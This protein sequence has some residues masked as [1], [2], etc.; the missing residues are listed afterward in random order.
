MV[1]KIHTVLQVL[2]DE[3]IDIACVQET[4]LSSESSVTTSII[5]QA[6]YNISHVFRNEKRG[7]GVAILWKEKFKSFKQNCKVQPKTYLSLQH[8]CAVFNFNPKLIIISIYRLQEIPFTVFLKEL[9]SLINDHFNLTHSLI[10]IG[11]FNAHFE[12]HELHDT[13]LLSDLTSSFGLSQLIS[14]PTHKAGHTLDLVFLNNFELQFTTTPPVSFS[15]GDHFPVYLTLYNLYSPIM[16]STNETVKYRDIRGINLVEFSADLCSQLDVVSSNEDFKSQ[17]Q[18]FSNITSET[19]ERHAPIKTKTFARKNNIPWQDS[20]YRKERA[21]RRKL[22]RKWRK[23]GKKPGPERTAYIEQRSKC[24][25][26]A[27]SKRSHFY[28]QLIQKNEGDQSSLFKVVSQVLDKQKSSTTLPQF[29]NQPTNLANRFNSYYFDKVK[30]IRAEI[31]TIDSSDKF[32]CGQATFNGTPL[33][34]FDPVSVDELSEILKGRTIKT[35]HNDVLPR[36][37]MKGVFKDLLPYICDLINLSLKTGCMDGVTEATIVPL[38]KKLGLDP[39]VLK[40]YRPVSDIVLISKLIETVVLKRLN[41][42]ADNH[43]LQCH[44]QHAYKKYHSTETLLLKVV[45]D[46]LVGYDSNNATILFLLD[47]S[48]AFDTVDSEKLLLILENEYGIKG[49]ALKWFRSFLIGRT[50]RVRIHESLSDCLDVLFGVPQGSVLGPVLF[51]IYTRSLY[52]IISAAG[53]S[54]SGYADDSN[55]R[56]SF[57]LCFQHN[58]ITQQLPKLM[59]QITQWM[60][61]FFLKINPDKTEIILFLPNARKNHPTINGTFFSNG[62]CIRFSEVVTNLGIKL[63]RFLSFE[64]HVNSTVAHCYKLLKDVSSIRSL[65]TI[66]ETEM[67]VHSVIT[68]RLDYCNSLFYNLN[69]SIIDKFQKVQNAAARVVLKLKKHDSV[70]AELVNLHW[71]RINERIIFKLLVTIFKCLNGLA[72]VELRSLINLNDTDNCTLRYIFMDSVYGRR[73]FQYAA[74]RLWN[75]LPIAVRKISTLDNF[76]SKIKYHLFNHSSEFMR[77]VNRYL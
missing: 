18:Q 42:H 63:D 65:I 70:R 47:L 25:I 20:E 14:G 67:L 48:A 55:A 66:H 17:Y 57:S 24:G 62:T 75:A 56:Q 73:S 40:N 41:K 58:I 7:A 36:A 49:M 22:E 72:P 68:S 8:Q 10:L 11:D 74:P 54:T 9:D 71:L 50:Q 35:A 32:D 60:N 59:D 43:N 6:G 16:Q 19:L 12:R 26:L 34:I 53:F 28:R 33:D 46:V 51:N 27:S 77:S 39:E 69:K 5:K 38:L 4:W 1:N 15:I 37:V 45:N 30:N 31:P 21:L 3:D 64:S 44:F 61:N 23:S 29:D 76:K 13:V 52:N 2:S